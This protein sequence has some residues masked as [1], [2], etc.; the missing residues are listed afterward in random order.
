MSEA[1]NKKFN[2]ERPTALIAN[3]VKGKGVSFIEG[4]GKWHHRI[5]SDEEFTLIKKELM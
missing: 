2:N 3:T 1:F 4:H 5:P